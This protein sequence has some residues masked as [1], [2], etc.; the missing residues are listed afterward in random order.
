MTWGRIRGI[1]VH[2][3]MYYGLIFAMLTAPTQTIKYD[4]RSACYFDGTYV[5]AIISSFQIFL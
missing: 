5:F 1:Q 2:T 4:L 3:D